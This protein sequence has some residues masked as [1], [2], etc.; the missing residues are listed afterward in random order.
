[1][2]SRH[3]LISKMAAGR[4]MGSI[5][6]RTGSFCPWWWW[7]NMPQVRLF[8]KDQIGAPPGLGLNRR[9][10]WPAVALDMG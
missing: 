10:E 3:A 2:I 9:G 7:Q 5:C 4:T 1:M 8:F 6:I